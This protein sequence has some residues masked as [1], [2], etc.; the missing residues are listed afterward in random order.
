MAQKEIIIKVDNNAIHLNPMLTVPIHLTNI[1]IKHLKFRTHEEIFWKVELL[2]YNE[3]TKCWK[4]KV[5]DYSAS[6]IKNFDKQESTI[7]IERIAFEKFD[8]LNF[9]RHLMSYHKINL[10]SILENHDADGF[11]RQETK[12]AKVATSSVEALKTIPEIIP[13]SIPSASHF[14]ATEHKPIVN[15]ITVKFNVYFTEACFMLGYVIFKKHIK[16][17]GR[18]IDFKI[19][20]DFILAEF[21]NVKFWFAKK[22]KNRRFKVV[23]LITTTDGEFTEATATSSDIDKITPELIESVKYQRTIALTKSPKLTDPDK[24]LFTAE[25]IFSK[26][27]S[28]DI[29]G[30]VFIQTEQDI[31]SILI[32][33]NKIRNRKQLEYLSGSKQSERNKLRFTLCPNFGFLFLIEGKENN[34]FVWELLNS[35][36]TYIWSIDKSDI[37]IELQYKRIEASINTIRDSGRETY[38]RAYRNNHNYSDLVFRVI[39]HDNITSD[40]V[41]GFVKWKHKL[42]EQLT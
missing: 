41:D 17:V 15:T 6:D 24:S 26:V 42:D 1:P 22:L 4:V 5:V 18:E 34:H 13:P 31:V 16:E 19:M 38:Q 21:E 25:E 27:E 33:K 29:E 40:F 12:P 36:A 2:E 9:E 28:E 20:N 39:E 7:E 32:D 37:E 30:N 14:V 10:I 8:W 3:K 11:F 35:H 23:A